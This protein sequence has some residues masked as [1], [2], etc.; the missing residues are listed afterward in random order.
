MGRFSPEAYAKAASTRRANQTHCKHGHAFTESNTYWFANKRIGWNIRI[1][2]SCVRRRQGYPEIVQSDLITGLVPQH[3]TLRQIRAR[4]AAQTMRE[5][6]AVYPGNKDTS[7][8]NLARRLR[9]KAPRKSH[10]RRPKCVRQDGAMIR[11]DVH[12]GFFQRETARLRQTMIAA[13]PDKGGTAAKFR[14][15]HRRWKNFEVTEQAWYAQYGL[16]PPP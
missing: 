8:A 14:L 1:C 3:T 10:G 12:D 6:Y 2:R 7:A 9:P 4:L 5:R 16:R 15:A 13:H 11:I